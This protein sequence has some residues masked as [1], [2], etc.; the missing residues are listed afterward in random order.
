MV[1]ITCADHHAFSLLTNE[2]VFNAVDVL[3]GAQERVD[4][5]TL[6]KARFDNLCKVYG[7]NPNP[8]GVLACKELRPY[9]NPA[10]T[11]RYDWLHNMLQDGV[12]T[13]EAFEIMKC[14]TYQEVHDFLKN[15]G[16]EFPMASKAKSKQL[17]RLF[18]DYRS[19]I[20]EDAGKLKCGASELLGVYGMLRFYV[21]TRVPDEPEWRLRRS[22]FEAACDILDCL[23]QAKRGLISACS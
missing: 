11:L 10:Y 23:L 22:S 18:D 21:E 12:F 15:E 5:H 6:T 20:S 8:H 2:D 14:T 1:E 3:A 9:L 4:A 17:F 7:M 13:V 19:N 16:W